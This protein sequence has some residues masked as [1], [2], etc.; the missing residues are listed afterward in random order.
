M[1]FYCLAYSSILKMEAIF[2]SEMSV[3]FQRRYIPEDRSLHN[4]RCEN[5]KSYV[6]F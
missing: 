4:P 2:S 1:L 3:D 6:S 5:L